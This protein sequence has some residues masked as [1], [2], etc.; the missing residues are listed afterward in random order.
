MDAVLA[1]KP[2]E[3][4]S[5]ETDH[6]IRGSNPKITLPIVSKAPAVIVDQFRGVEMVENSELQPIEASQSARCSN[7]QVSVTSLKNRLY[8]VIRQTVL[9]GPSALV[10]FPG[11]AVCP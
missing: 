11:T 9:V 10:K 5:S 7:P 3:S 4:I 6:P 1:G 2:A 8:P